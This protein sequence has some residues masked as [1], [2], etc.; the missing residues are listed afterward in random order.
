MVV[1]AQ[2]QNKHK[3]V[4]RTKQLF[5]SIDADGS[6]AVT[7][8]ELEQHLYDPQV[9]EHFS[10]LEIDIDDAWTFFQLLDADN[11]CIIDAAEYVEGCLRLKGYARSLDMARLMYEHRWM[12]K[13]LV[14]FIDSVTH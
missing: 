5:K 13:R 11:S 1:Q 2:L 9:R 3:Y 14:A 12:T 7:I 10:A 8:R 6:G 4:Q